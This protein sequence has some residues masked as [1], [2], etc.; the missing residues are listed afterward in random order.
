MTNKT[1]TIRIAIRKILREAVRRIF[2]KS[3]RIDGSIIPSRTTTIAGPKFKDSKSYLESAEKEA[4]RLVEHFQCSLN[5]RVLD[6]GCGLGRLPIGIIRIIGELDYTGIDVDNISIN[7]CKRFIGKYH[8]S[9]KFHHL[10]VYNERYN[11][12]GTKIDSNFHFDFADS[13]VDIIYLFSVFSHTTEEDMRIYLKEFSRILR[14][15]GFIFFTT[16]V[17]ENVPDITFNPGNYSIKCSGPLHIVRYNKEYIFSI[18]KEYGFTIV[19]FMQSVEL[20]GQSG[21]YLGQGKK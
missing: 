2:P 8:P 1:I 10:S 11:N 18:I 4:K 9:F 12:K 6:I 20:D 16:F 17:E 15:N 21:I 3:V 7:W 5:S 14:E 19:N 13:S